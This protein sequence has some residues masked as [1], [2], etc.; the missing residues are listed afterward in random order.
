MIGKELKLAVRS[1]SWSSGF[2]VVAV[3]TLA[4]GIGASTAIF[5]VVR[6][7]LLEALP[8]DEPDQLVRFWTYWDDYPRGSISE[9]EY[10]DYLDQNQVFRHI[11]IYRGRSSNLSVGDGDPE[12]VLI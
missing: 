3:L 9:P 7:V 5:T 11:A 4:L 8:Y 2:T 10:F 12:R 6:S 1:L